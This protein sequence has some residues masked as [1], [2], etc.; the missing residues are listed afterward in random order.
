MNPVSAVAGFGDAAKTVRARTKTAKLTGEF[1]Q[2]R[3]IDPLL[4]N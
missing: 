4:I 3:F 1:F 2:T